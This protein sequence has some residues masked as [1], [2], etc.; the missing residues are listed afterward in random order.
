M[1][2]TLQ[3]NS[4]IGFLA[5]YVVG[6]ILTVGVWTFIKRVAKEDARHHDHQLADL[7]WLARLGIALFVPWF[8]LVLL[9]QGYEWLL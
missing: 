5:G 4:G 9:L 2:S 7:H 6:G 8:F 1:R 3:S